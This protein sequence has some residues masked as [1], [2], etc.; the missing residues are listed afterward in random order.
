MTYSRILN[1]SE[2]PDKKK[3]KLDLEP[4]EPSH[5][6][7]TMSSSGVSVMSLPSRSS[8]SSHSKW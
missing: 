2:T 1:F 5:V 7:D 4:G 8:H 6:R 3:R